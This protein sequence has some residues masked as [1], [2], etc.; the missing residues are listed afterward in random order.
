MNRILKAL[1]P[2]LTVLCI[3]GCEEKPILEGTIIAKR[4]EPENSYTIMQT[5]FISENQSITVP[6]T[7]Y[8]DEDFIL[9]LE[10]YTAAGIRGKQ[11]LY[12]TRTIYE[13]TH[14]GDSFVTDESTEFT[15]EHKQERSD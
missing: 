5:F 7:V 15:D 8:D 1:L 14:I 9:V 2:V 12:V 11:E 6:L 4:Y 13:I 3:L 10:G